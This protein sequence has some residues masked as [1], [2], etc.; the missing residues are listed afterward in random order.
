MIGKLARKTAKMFVNN[1]TKFNSVEMYQYA[2][3]IILSTFIFFVLTIMIGAILSVL[4]ESIVFYFSFLLIRLYAGGY[5]AS[6]EITCDII[7]SISI[8]GCV[9]LIRLSKTYEFQIQ[10]IVITLFS[11]L[12]IFAL[13]PLDTPEKPLSKKE[14][15]YFRKISWLILLIIS[16]LVLISFIFEWKFLFAPSCL[17]LILESI[18]LVAGKVKRVYQLKN[19]E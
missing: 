17:S 11:V 3:F 13:C 16:V 5:H 15:K 2:F 9:F 10:L 1:N 4:F 14:V 19:A 18:L 12:C 7:T 8:F 6:K